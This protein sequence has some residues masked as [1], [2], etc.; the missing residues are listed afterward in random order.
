MI[1]DDKPL[2]KLTPDGVSVCG[3]P[4]NGKH[5]LGCNRMVPLK[6]ICILERAEQNRITSIDV[7][8]A[9][10]MLL[11]QSFRTGTT[12]GTILL[13]NILDKLTKKVQLYRLGC[14]MDPQAV[15]V[16]YEGMKG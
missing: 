12:E 15:M 13:F 10:P 11:Q 3:T 6:A 5:G 14:N 4:W 8:E 2:L 9:L 7:A 16:A 1:N